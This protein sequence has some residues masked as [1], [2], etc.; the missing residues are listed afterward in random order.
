MKI[1]RIIFIF[2]CLI[3]FIP[4]L[5]GISVYNDF[6]IFYEACEHWLKGDNPYSQTYGENHLKYYYSPLFLILFSPFTLI[7]LKFAKT[8]WLLTQFAFLYRILNL[9]NLNFQNKIFH[10]KIWIQL[11]SI[12]MCYRLVQINLVTGQITL[13]I[14]WIMLEFYNLLL[15]NKDI[16]AA[17][18]IALGINIKILPI[19]LAPY[20]LFKKKYKL[21]LLTAIITLSISILPLLINTNLKTLTTSWLERI[22][23]FAIT[24]STQLEERG[25]MDIGATITKFISSNKIHD[26]PQLNIISLDLKSQILIANIIKLALILIWFIVLIKNPT[27]VISYLMGIALIPFVFPHQREYSYTF[28]FPLFLHYLY[29][30]VA[31]LTSRSKIISNII[32]IFCLFVIT[33]AW[34]IVDLTGANINFFFY[35]YRLFC[36]GSLI[37]FL[38]YAFINLGRDRQAETVK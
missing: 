4:S 7:P 11:I 9:L 3:L 30:H 25:F 1:N 15:K 27:S 24:H 36:I 10:A 32:F 23:P 19:I 37:F 34:V 28:I 21:F 29:Q 38:Y 18:L 17:S 12:F 6:T 20:V 26:E 13:L 31:S 22:N 5:R 16:K 35:D 2:F 14:L 33:G 8:I